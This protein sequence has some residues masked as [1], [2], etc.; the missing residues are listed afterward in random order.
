VGF[1]ESLMNKS[2][3]SFGCAVAAVL[4]LNIGYSHAATA[5]T[6]I[7]YAGRVI[8]PSDGN[9]SLNQSI[10]VHD[11]TI[12]EIAAGRKNEEGAQEI[13]LSALTVLPGLIDCHDHITKDYKGRQSLVRLLATT[14]VDDGI[15]GV[16]NARTTLLAGF[17]TIRDVGSRAGSALALKRQIDAHVVPGPKLWVSDQPLSSTGGHADASIG[18]DPAIRDAAWEGALV[19]SPDQARRAVRTRWRE[20]ADLIKMMA[21]TTSS[22]RPGI[23]RLDADEMQ[24]IVREAHTLGMKV[25]AHSAGDYSS[26]HDAIDAGVDSIEHADLSGSLAERQKLYREMVA[27]GTYLTPTLYIQQYIL[28]RVKA[29][30]MQTSAS[31]EF[32]TALAESSKAVMMEAYK[33]GVKIAMGT[34]A[35]GLIPHGDNG[36]EIVAMVKAG[37]LP[38]DALRA[39]TS[40]AADLIGAKQ[41]GQVRTGYKADIIALKGNPLSDVTSVMDVD[42]VMQGGELIKKNG[43]SLLR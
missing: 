38:M 42:F 39:A 15:L 26:V 13:D 34:D 33:A 21:S 19:D 14:P 2:K 16:A 40:S 35:T 8:N 30:E 1:K 11:D 20:G 43:Q 9:V 29:G 25:A 32:W 17:T 22:A 27:H 6:V 28:Q 31:V 36:E 23:Q 41:V 12:V 24:T 5:K 3:H 10:V 37:M 7:I 4:A 18:L